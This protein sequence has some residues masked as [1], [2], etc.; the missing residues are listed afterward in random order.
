MKKKNFRIFRNKIPF[1]AKNSIHCKSQS[2]SQ[3][4]CFRLSLA[5]TS[6]LYFFLETLLS[7]IRF[8]YQNHI[9]IPFSNLATMSS[10]K[11]H[12]SRIIVFFSLSHNRT[13]LHNVQQSTMLSN[14]CCCLIINQPLLHP[15]SDIGLL[16][17][18]KFFL[19]C[20]FA[21]REP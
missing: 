14:E 18:S 11:P 5:F 20:F 12:R 6:R 4:H 19:P 8:I 9:N 3:I 17:F 21:A 13:L 2:R 15:S 10:I 1:I 16:H 7:F